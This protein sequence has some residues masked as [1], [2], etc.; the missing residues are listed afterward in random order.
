MAML[1]PYCVLWPNV[2][3]MLWP[4]WVQAGAKCCAQ[5][6]WQRWSHV[7]RLL[8]PPDSQ[9]PLPNQKFETKMTRSQNSPPITADVKSE[10]CLGAP[11][12]GGLRR[13][14]PGIPARNVRNSCGK[15]RRAG[16]KHHVLLVPAIKPP[17]LVWARQH[18]R[19]ITRACVDR[20]STGKH[21][22]FA[23]A[24]KLPHLPGCGNKCMI[25]ATGHVETRPCAMRGG[26]D[27]KPRKHVL[28]PNKQCPKA[29]KAC[30]GAPTLVPPPHAPMLPNSRVATSRTQPTCVARPGACETS[31][32]FSNRKGNLHAC[33]APPLPHASMS[34]PN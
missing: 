14:T 18:A 8:Q 24:I 12:A 32:D 13:Q 16:T 10:L 27:L 19:L 31:R 33:H 21:V 25:A 11:L 6:L 5:M 9:F 30:T 34:F 26:A 7:W 3:A 2:V 17:K 20:K 29:V 22:F 1:E 28:R 23:P 15:R 4:C